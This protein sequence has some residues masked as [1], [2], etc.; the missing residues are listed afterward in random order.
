MRNMSLLG[1]IN[2]WLLITVFRKTFK[3]KTRRN[4]ILVDNKT[5]ISMVYNT[6]LSVIKNNDACFQFKARDSFANH[7]ECI[8]TQ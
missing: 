8:R 3:K 6:W 7:E 5:N 2:S 4:S 1:Y